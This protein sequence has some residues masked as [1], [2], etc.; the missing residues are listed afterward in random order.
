MSAPESRIADELEAPSSP[1]VS[2]GKLIWKRFL[3]NKVAVGSAILFILIVIFSISAIGIG[4]IHGWWKYTYTEL[5]EQVSQ[6]NPSA[7]HPFGQDR[8]GKDYF[9][10]TM[11]GVQNSVLVMVV[12]GLIASVVGV[13]VGAIAGYFRGIVDAILMRITDVFIVIPALVIGSVVG[14]AFGGLGAFF[15][16]LM[17]GFFSWMGIARLVR[18]EFLSLRER[19]FV[20]AARVAGASDM[21]II[22]KHILPNAIGVVIVSSTLIM[23]SAILLETALSFLGYGIKAPDVSL[24]LLISSNQSAFQ[25]RP[26]LFW[27]PGAFIVTL[28]LLVNFVGDGLRDAFDPRHRRFNLRKMREEEPEPGEG[29]D[30]QSKT[31]AALAED[32]L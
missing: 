26:W 29:G 27:W 20:E 31:G 9:A 19:E 1:P 14:H 16:A 11:R 28:A 24:G 8:I 6:G 15:L 7:E 23:A 32:V 22:F 21:R 25:T 17:L 18:G 13:V 2:Q 5:N 4:P 3:S 10:L 30:G 12:L